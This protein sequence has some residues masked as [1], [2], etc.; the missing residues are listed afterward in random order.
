MRK[1]SLMGLLAAVALPG[2]AS[3]QT[4][5]LYRDRQDIREE[6]RE[7]RDARDHGDRGDI[8]EERGELRDARHEYR[9]DW[10][11][12][13]RS[14]RDVYRMPR[15]EGPRN[16]R[17]RHMSV[18][19]RFAPA[20]YSERYVIVNPWRYRLP[21]THGHQRWVRYGD[22]DVALV[23]IRNGRILRIYRDFFW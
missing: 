3:A 15:Y 5:E 2:M 16:Y 9:D 12:Y 8:R 10:R 19:N 11:D 22:N 13:R 20:Y 17:Y 4:R 18:G 6:Q 14:H 23:N 1:A 21:R 7:L